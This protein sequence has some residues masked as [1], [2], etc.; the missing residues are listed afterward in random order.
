MKDRDT[1]T[2]AGWDFII[3]WAING[4]TNDGYPFFWAMPPEPPP[5][6]PRRTVAVQDKI[7]LESIRNVEMAAGGTFRVDEEGKAVYKSRYARNL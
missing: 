7:T 6:A 4:I 3:I 1:F 2:D 5:D